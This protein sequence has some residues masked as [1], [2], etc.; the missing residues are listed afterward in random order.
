MSWE[1][2][3]SH[4]KEQFFVL[5]FSFNFL[6]MHFMYCDEDKFMI[7]RTILSSCDEDVPVV[8]MYR[9]SGSV[10]CRAQMWMGAVNPNPPGLF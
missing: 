10:I 6:N 2:F 7:W 9:P 1:G 3:F 4:V 5:F 8:L